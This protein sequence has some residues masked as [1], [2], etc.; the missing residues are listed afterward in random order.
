MSAIDDARHKNRM[1]GTN[2]VDSESL[3]SFQLP[4][5]L[6]ERIL[7]RIK[8][9][10]TLMNLVKTVP[11]DRM[12]EN[13]PQYGT[14]RLSGDTR[15]EGGRRNSS[16]DVETGQVKFGVEDQQYYILV[17]PKKDALKNTH[18][19]QDEFG[20]YIV[21]TFIERFSTDLPVIGMRAGASTGNLTSYAN[22]GHLDNTFT[23]WIARAEGDDQSVD[24]NGNSTR[25]GLED[26][27]TPGSMPE[28][29]NT[30]SNGNPQPVDEDTINKAILTLDERYRDEDQTKL[31]CSTDVVQ[32]FGHNLT[33]REDPL[34]AAIVFGEEELTPHNYDLMGIKEWPSQ[35]M[36]FTDPN[37][38][39]FGMYRDVDIDQ[40]RDSDKVHE[41]R[42][43]SRNWIEAQF[44]YQISRMQAGVL[45]TGIKPP[46]A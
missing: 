37:N 33:E 40:T 12:Q 32:Q 24:A 29:D 17:E 46:L 11:L 3:D 25:L 18:Y 31:L 26:T 42:L 5:K 6:A 22:A 2:K 10:V 14:R 27:D 1:A 19:D 30:N 36:M 4:P 8:N 7:E 13:V 35:Y 16:S 21:D 38:L 43:H 39:A 23:G 34:G 41:N 15:D 45:V 9:E 20:Q 44:D 28:L